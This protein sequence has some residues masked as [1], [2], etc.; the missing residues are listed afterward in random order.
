M[1]ECNL[2]GHIDAIVSHSDATRQAIADE[3][4]AKLE[5]WK[6][7]LP[8]KPDA[9]KARV[10]RPSLVDVTTTMMNMRRAVKAIGDA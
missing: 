2:L 5:L 10:H 3:E 9:A 8:P 1:D 6:I 7:G 4:R